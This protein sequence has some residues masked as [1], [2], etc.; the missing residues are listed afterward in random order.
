LGAGFEAQR[1]RVHV[2]LDEGVAGDKLPALEMRATGRAEIH[3][4]RQ[5]Q[6][7][8]PIVR[9]PQCQVIRRVDLAHACVEHRHLRAFEERAA[10]L[11]KGHH[12]KRAGRVCNHG[13]RIHSATLYEAL[14]LVCAAHD[15]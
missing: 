9:E 5:G 2:A 4:E 6:I 14:R 3:D 7:A 15:R 10:F 11:R 12:H 13:R 8:C 1:A